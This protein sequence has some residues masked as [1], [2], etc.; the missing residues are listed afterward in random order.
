MADH[1]DLVHYLLNVAMVIE[2]V[3]ETHP[4]HTEHVP[5]TIRTHNQ[6]RTF[7]GGNDYGKSIHKQKP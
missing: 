5:E 3:P 4:Q 6:N 7:H 1:V 2:S